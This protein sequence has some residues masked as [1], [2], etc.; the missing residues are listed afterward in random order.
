M[1]DG[2]HWQCE[3]CQNVNKIDFDDVLSHM[4]LKC[5]QSNENILEMVCVHKENQR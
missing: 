4:C 1:K 2:N 3:K 5:H